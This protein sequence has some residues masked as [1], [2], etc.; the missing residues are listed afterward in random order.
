MAHPIDHVRAFI[1]LTPE[2]EERLRALM[3]EQK[4]RRGAMID[5]RNDLKAYALF[6][7]H[8]SA[9][10]FYIEGGKEHTY[11]FAFDDEFVILSQQLLHKPDTVMIVEL[12][13]P[14]TL[15]YIPHEPVHALFDDITKD[16]SDAGALFLITSLVKYTHYLEERLLL[17]QN[18]SARQRYQWLVNR[19]PRILERAT[20]TQIASFLGVTKE[21]LYRIRSDK[22]GKSRKD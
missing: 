8:G 20:I 22:Y 5:A 13:E 12:L 10:V 15:I 21:T 6:I 7:K 19:Y 9:R 3:K 4:F 16:Q 14:S 1:H 18:T 2:Q 17:L 11:S